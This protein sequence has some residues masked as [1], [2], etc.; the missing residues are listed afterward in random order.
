MRRD[1]IW[2]WAAEMDAQE[3]FVL[4][5]EQSPGTGRRMVELTG[6]LLALLQDFPY[7]APVWRPPLRRAV[8]RKTPYALFYAVV[9][10]LIVI[11]GLQD[12]RRDSDRLR[13]DL[14]RRLPA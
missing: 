6:Q 11:I 12:V 14:L 2:I 1:V 5:E 7:I 8:L 13:Q 9:P 4:L 10:N 3:V